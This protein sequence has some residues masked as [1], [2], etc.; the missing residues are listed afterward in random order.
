M[1]PAP[2]VIAGVLIGAFN[3]TWTATLL[4]AVVWPLIFCIYVSVAD[5]RRLGTAAAQL[6][7][8]GHESPLFKVYFIEFMTALSTAVPVA[9]VAHLVRSLVT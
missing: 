1:I 4:A 5:R 3:T 7:A 6:K 8:N 2:N 9:A